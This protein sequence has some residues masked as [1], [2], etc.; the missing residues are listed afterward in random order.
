MKT[1]LLAHELG[2]GFGH[3]NRLLVLG[4][5]LVQ[6]RLIFAVPGW[7]AARPV[8]GRALGASV[9]VRPVGEWQEAAVYGELIGGDASWTLADMLYRYGF[10]NRDRV[11]AGARHWRLVLDELQPSLVIGDFAPMLRIATA[12][13]LP[14]VVVGNGFT[15][16]PSLSPL[17][18]IRPDQRSASDLSRAREAEVLA[19]VN[20][21]RRELGLPDF[22]SV[23]DLFYGDET[24]AATLEILDPYRELRT[25][26]V[27]QPF[28]IPELP[29]GPAFESR[30]GP[31]VFC[32]LDADYP[33]I[34]PM[35][36]A[37]NNLPRPSQIFVR[38]ID[39]HQLTRHCAPQVRIHDGP[40]DF[41]AVLPQTRLLVHHAN[42]GTAAA[43]LLAGVPQLLLPSHLEHDLTALGLASL[44]CSVG[45][46]VD[47]AADPEVLRGTIETLLVHRDLQSAAIAHARRFQAMRVAVP[48]RDVLQ[49]C[50][51]LL[52]GTSK[53][54]VA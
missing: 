31:H 26:P 29:V 13:R 47:A 53:I 8:I 40:A 23:A 35:L 52:S 38:G 2:Q 49:A 28:N 11:A 51:R 46:R 22:A 15:V 17:P 20:A 18:G 21:V 44:S 9:E 37:L 10:A 30:T 41:A 39:A 16:P 50:E 27:L 33:G 45:L 43:G 6:H 36:T 19:A 34:D 3:V 48:E 32:Y 25:E 4:K 24:F 1:I 5:S 14:S 7:R 42:L 54:V 12:G